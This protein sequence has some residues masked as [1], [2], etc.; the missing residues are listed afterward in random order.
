MEFLY[1]NILKKLSPNLPSEVWQSLFVSLKLAS[2]TVFILLFIG[3]SLAYW[4]N[5]S[6]SI[7]APIVQV[8]LNLPLVLP[9]VVLGFYVLIMLS[10]ESFIG[11]ILYEMTG[12]TLSF[13]FEGLIIGSILYN[14]PFAVQPFQA[15][16]SSVP[17]QYKDASAAL[18]AGKWQTF[19][20]IEIQCASKGILV[21]SILCFAHTIGEFGV[22]LMIGGSI[23]K[24][25]K[26]ASIALYEQVQLLN[27]HDAHIL[28]LVLVCISSFFMFIM[29]LLQGNKKI[30][31]NLRD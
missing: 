26:V 3:L 13:T 25:T 22:V 18:G 24:V 29:I 27:Y 20:R 23:P 30:M 8:I 15:A 16:L 17:K 21:G 14:L 31:D 1:H 7:F 19:W 9:P 12:K 10:P 28:A 4:L 5:K 11:K 6:R 2:V